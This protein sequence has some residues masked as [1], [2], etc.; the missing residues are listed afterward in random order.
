MN[1]LQVSSRLQGWNPNLTFNFNP[2]FRFWKVNK[3]STSLIISFL[4]SR[5]RRKAGTGDS[6]PKWSKDQLL[7][8]R[9][10]Q[11][12]TSIQDKFQ[13]IKIIKGP[14]LAWNLLMV[15]WTL[16]K[17]IPITNSFSY[18]ELSKV[19]GICLSAACDHFGERASVGRASPSYHSFGPVLFSYHGF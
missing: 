8:F 2:L 11:T 1:F 13:N 10:W 6:D 9:E 18:L 7:S 12:S 5:A 4:D 17:Q 16:S 15:R 19:F 14:H 3:I